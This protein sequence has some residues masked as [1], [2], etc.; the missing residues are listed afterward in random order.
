MGDKW[1][2]SERQVGDK[3]EISV[4]VCGPDHPERNASP[5]TKAKSCGP[6]TQPFES[7][8]NN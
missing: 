6:G 1:E 4:K 7:L 3:L 5:E 2:T 8:G